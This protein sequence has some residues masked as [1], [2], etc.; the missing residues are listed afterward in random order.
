MRLAADTPGEI[1][2]WVLGFGTRA[3]VVE[4]QTLTDDIQA[5]L[6]IYENS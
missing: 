6:K 5:G 3:R 2:R 1:K 4:P